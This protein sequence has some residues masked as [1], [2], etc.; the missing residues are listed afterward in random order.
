MIAADVDDTQSPV[1]DS[2]SDEQKAR[3]LQHACLCAKI[4]DDYRGKDTVVLDLSGV[5][6]IVDYFVITTGNSR[7]QMHAIA[8]EVDRVLN[9]QGSS[10]IGLEGYRQS[11]WILQDYGDV[12]LHVF[13]DESRATYDLEHLWADATRI[14]WRDVLGITTPPSSADE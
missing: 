5:T 9:E 8:E 4:A 1:P 14:D 11:A 2:R 3:S 13:D 12:V 10:R 7:R 6:P